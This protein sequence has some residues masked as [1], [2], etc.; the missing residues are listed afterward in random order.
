MTTN[1]RRSK[2]RRNMDNSNYYV[3]VDITK[4]EESSAT[5]KANPPSEPLEWC[6]RCS[7]RH[8]YRSITDAEN[9]LRREHFHH[10]PSIQDDILRQWIVDSEQLW[11]YQ[12]R[13]D[14]QQVLKQI[15]EHCV[16]LQEFKKELCHGVTSSGTFD[17]STYRMPA[18]LVNAFKRISSLVIY[19]SF[20]ARSAHRTSKTYEDIDSAPNSFIGGEYGLLMHRLTYRGLAAEESMKDAKDHLMLM[21]QAHDYSESIGYEAVGPEFIM[22]LVMGDLC[23][24]TNFQNGLE[25]IKIYQEYASKLVRPS[26]LLLQTLRRS[27]YVLNEHTK[28]DS[29]H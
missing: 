26:V 29:G 7:G 11:R 25:L 1:F 14:G 10:S 4:D 13:V 27:W 17:R 9:H 22:S 2:N 23:R 24:R 16:N 5:I 18:S 21:N 19:S 8:K 3:I 20:V 6:R 28:V 12:R 15:L